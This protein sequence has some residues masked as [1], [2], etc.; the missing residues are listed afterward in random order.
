VRA[1]RAAL[2]RIA[3]VGGGAILSVI[4]AAELAPAQAKETFFTVVAQV[5]P[6]ILLALV[7][8]A[9][10]IGSPVLRAPRRMPLARTVE[11]VRKVL[12]A[13]LVAALLVAEWYALDVVSD[14]AEGPA[15][16]WVVWLGLTW[17]FVT[18]A[19]LAVFGT[20]RPRATI[21]ISSEKRS[22]GKTF[23][24]L[25]LGNEYGD[26]DVEP[27]LNMYIQPGHGPIHK[28]KGDGTAIAEIS[29]FTS[30][31]PTRPLAPEWTCVG[32]NVR[33]SAGDKVLKAYLIDPAALRE[34]FE[35][36]VRLDH[37]HLPG[38]RVDGRAKIPAPAQ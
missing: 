35:I 2:E 9:R 32:E 27:V 33:L 23:V 34:P 37:V 31:D 6:V 20:K 14:Q 10:A 15:D 25:A 28:C 1:A 30:S 12:E 19:V 26:I 16:P 21:D 5:L 13:L 22:D 38:G 11:R 18:V 29:P 7:I 4:V 36:L 17:G 8:E 24:R 3:P